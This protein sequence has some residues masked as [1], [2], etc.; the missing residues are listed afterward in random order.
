MIRWIIVH[1]CGG[2]HGELGIA[3]SVLKWFQNYLTD[4]AHRVKLGD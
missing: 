2:L 1:Y 3:K 4:R